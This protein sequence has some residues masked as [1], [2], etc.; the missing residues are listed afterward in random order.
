MVLP[1]RSEKN[2]LALLKLELALD[3]EDTDKQSTVQDIKALMA[4]VQ[5]EA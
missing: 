4:A 1:V 2:L 5:L 3:E